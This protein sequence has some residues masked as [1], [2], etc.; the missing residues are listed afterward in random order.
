MPDLSDLTTLYNYGKT[1]LKTMLQ[2]HSGA[3]LFVSI[4]FYENY[5]AS[6]ITVLTLGLMLTLSVNDSH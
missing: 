3:I 6:V 5:V 2:P 1:R 4:D